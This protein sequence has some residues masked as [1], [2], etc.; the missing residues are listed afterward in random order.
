M[1]YHVSRNGQVYG[2]YTRED[3]ERYLQTGNVLPGDMARA[4]DATEWVPIAQLFPGMAGVGATV[5]PPG[6]I[7]APVPGYPAVPS[8]YPDPPNLH[9]GLVLLFGVITCGLFILAWDIVQAV[10]MRRVNPRSKALFFYIAGDALNLFGSMVRFRSM[11]AGGIQYGI[12]F[13]LPFGL[14]T[15]LLLLL[16]RFDMKRSLE[17]HYNGP[18]PIGLSLS[19]VMSLLFGSL[20]FQYHMSR[21]NEQKRFAGYRSG[22]L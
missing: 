18:E 13:G 19:A 10:W 16:G 11:L 20:Y 9:W 14:I 8:P 1:L 17:E 5:P 3:I 4:D 2:P 15:L 6:F 7:P 21:I 12:A 22:M